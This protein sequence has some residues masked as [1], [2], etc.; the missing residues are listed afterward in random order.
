MF[1]LI[2][3][4]LALVFL[5]NGLPWFTAQAQ[6]IV[7][8]SP[9]VRF[10]LT[11][12]YMPVMVKGLIVDPKEPLKFEFLID[13][14]DTGL[15]G[16]AL[17]PESMKLMKYFLAA[18]TIPDEEM[19]VN[20]LPYEKDRI[21]AKSFGET[22]M[23]RDLLAQDYVLKQLVASLT[24]PEG[25]M[26]KKFWDRVGMVPVN[27]FNKVWI[28]PSK[29]EIFENSKG[30]FVMDAHMKVMLDED[31]LAFTN[32]NKT[33]PKG[34]TNT[35]AQHTTASDMVRQLI[36]PAIEKEVNEGEHFANL[37][38]IYQAMILATWY[39]IRL[40]ESILGKF[41]VDRHKTRG[42]AVAD[43][44]GN[45]RIYQ[46]YLA[47]FKR[48]AYNYIR[49]EVDPLTNAMIP[50]KYI[51]GGFDSALL[52]KVVNAGLKKGD[53][54]LTPHGDLA[55]VKAEARA[56]HPHEDAVKALY[57]SVRTYERKLLKRWRMHQFEVFYYPALGVY[58]KRLS[59]QQL[60]VLESV[61]LAQARLD[62]LVAD[63]VFFKDGHEWV[64]LQ[65]AVEPLD[66]V[67]KKEKHAAVVDDLLEQVLELNTRM[68]SRGVLHW[69]NRM[70][71]YGVIDGEDG[72]RK[73]VLLDL[74][75][76][77]DLHGDNAH[78]SLRWES[79]TFKRLL[80]HRGTPWT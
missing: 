71:N 70:S 45:E 43:S 80:G 5:F 12:P 19:W 18:M 8:P 60:W 13:S 15:K 49:E 24:Y 72:K 21:I 11:K 66:R 58:E 68:I 23:G 63:F 41:Y 17:K 32:N 36:V 73:V 14:G 3:F 51:S 62:G 69:D 74:G 30:A 22:E 31:Y 9:G 48:G 42:V 27:T 38:Q 55:M 47:A 1:K 53:P 75:G 77:F 20:L 54:V 57:E 4:L 34:T 56:N 79:I 46:Q 25:E 6:G 26:G 64:M 40:K 2:K 65:T 28:V 67:L 39:K 44:G 29:A 33:S 59:E 61:R 37:R 7:L 78:S 76:L 10:E 52:A 35:K 16:E 50:R